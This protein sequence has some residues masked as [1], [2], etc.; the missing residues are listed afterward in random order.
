MS[1]L[2]RFHSYETCGTVDG[3]GIR[4]ILFLQGC[5]MRC[6][7]CHNRDTWDLHGGKEISVEDLMKEVVT[8]RHFMNASGGGVT[9]SGGEAIL[10][11]E[12]VRDW[13]RACHEVGINTCLDTNGFVRHHDYIIDELIDETDLVM[14]DLKEMNE[15]IH[16][17]LIG[18]PNKRVLDFAKYLAERNKRTW[19]RHVVVP[20]YTDNDD[21]IH[22]LGYFIKDMQNIEKVELLPYHRLG[23]HKWEVLGDKYELEDV[24]PP[25]KELMEHVKGILE[26]YGLKNVKY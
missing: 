4:F 19:I 24:K 20:G 3:P 6:K 7:Y 14:L 2:G 13:F 5:L 12:F 16:E 21:D 17:S 18:V 11:T 8:Y 9:A 25:T 1:V 26:G 22:M 15:R 23:A 10:Q